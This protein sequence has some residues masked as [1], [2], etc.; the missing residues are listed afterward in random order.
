MSASYLLSRKWSLSN[1]SEITDAAGLKRFEVQSASAFSRK[2]A[3]C[4]PGGAEVAL[5]TRRRLPL[6]YEI[7][8]AGQLTTV[9]PHGFLGKRFEIDSPAGRLEATGN[10][11]GRQYSITRNGSPAA[12]VTQLRTF[13]QQFAVEVS[14]SEEPVLMLAVVLAIETIREDRKNSAAAGG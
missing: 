1:R 12:A 2:L 14:E 3:I 4:D 8:V 11:S 10:F 6:H 7:Q 5:L 13:R 9:Q